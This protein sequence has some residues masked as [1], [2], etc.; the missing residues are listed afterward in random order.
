MYCGQNGNKTGTGQW[1]LASP[2]ASDSSCV[3]RVIGDRASLFSGNYSFSIGVSP[4][5]SLKS[6]FIP[7]VE[8]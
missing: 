1:W 5:V 6:S 3:C 2:S 4:L 7:E 8:E